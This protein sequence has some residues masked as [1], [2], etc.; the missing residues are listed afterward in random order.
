[1]I[2]SFILQFLASGLGTFVGILAAAEIL[3]K[4]ANMSAGL[5]DEEFMAAEKASQHQNEP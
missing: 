3:A 2:V 4:I 5:A 1:M